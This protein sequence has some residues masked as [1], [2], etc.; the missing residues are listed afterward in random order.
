MRIRT[1]TFQWQQH[2]VSLG[3]CFGLNFFHLN[4]KNLIK[5]KL[6]RLFAEVIKQKVLALYLLCHAE[7]W[8]GRGGLC[9]GRA[10]DYFAWIC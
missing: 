4:K 7:G 6:A 10:G 1:L 3:F 2:S 9:A 8:Q 5:K